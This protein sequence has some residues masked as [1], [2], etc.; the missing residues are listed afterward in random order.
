MIPYQVKRKGQKEID[1]YN[2]LLR[3]KGPDEETI[4]L[5]EKESYVWLQNPSSFWNR[6]SRPNLDN[7]D[8]QAQIV[9]CFLYTQIEDT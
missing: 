5:L 4:E 9:G 2:K 8:P 3:Y 7:M 1:R 6:S